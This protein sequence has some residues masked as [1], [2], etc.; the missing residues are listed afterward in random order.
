VSKFISVFLFILFSVQVKAA[1]MLETD[2]GRIEYEIK[3]GGDL[4]VLFD[5]G[6]VSGMAGWDSI[7]DDL[8]AQITAIRFSRLGEGNSDSCTGQRS[9]SDYVKEVDQLISA[10]KIDRPIVYV[11]HSLGGVTARNFSAQHKD[12]VAALLMIDPANPR[13][14]DIVTQLNSSGGKAEIEA[15]KKNDYAMGEG[16]WCFLDLVWD[17]S[18]AAGFSEIGDIPVTLIAGVKVPKQPANAFESGQGR[19]LWGKYQSEWV[20]QFPKGKVI[21]TKNSGHMVQDDEPELVLIELIKLLDR[22]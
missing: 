5:A 11:S 20:K 15:I 6:A 12:D 18:P 19:K 8:P 16:K 9:S 21:L 22:L 3:K 13:D 17:K 1:T 10:L 2:G 14:V 4:T 7:W